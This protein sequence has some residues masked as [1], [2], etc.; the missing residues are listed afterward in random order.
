M[1]NN[2]FK[3]YIKVVKNKKLTYYFSVF[4]VL[5][6]SFVLANQ[7]NE[8]VQ[9]L[10]F[11]LD[12]QLIRLI[13]IAKIIFLCYYNLPLGLLYTLMISVLFTIS[14]ENTENFDNIPN[15]V[16][17][18]KIL[19]YNKNFKEPKKLIESNKKVDKKQQ[20][21]E[22]ER[23]KEN[24]KEE[25]TKQVKRSKKV[26]AVST[27]YYNEKKNKESKEKEEVE[28]INLNE[29]E[30]TIEKELKGK[31][32]HEFKKLEEYDS[33]SSESSDSNSSDSSTDSSDSEKEIEEVSM[34]KAREHMLNS[35]RNSLKK[36]Y[37]N[38]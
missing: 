30:D 2:I 20:E 18:G 23:E 3:I 16:D 19:K 13:V 25:N 11:L 21:I 9:G 32:S 1:L 24:E 22:D 31:M 12:F 6:I 37:L 29:E 35:L 27:D 15:L 4:T 14:T 5:F 26:S 17:K 36:R 8:L 34:N 28:E 33:S 10:R 38:D 7:E